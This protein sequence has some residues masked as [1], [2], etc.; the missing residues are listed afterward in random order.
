MKWMKS[1]ETNNLLVGALILTGII[2]FP[3][4]IIDNSLCVF[5]LLFMRTPCRTP[6]EDWLQ[7]RGSCADDLDI[8]ESGYVD[9]A[10]KH[11]HRFY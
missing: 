3:S 4:N 8:V 1:I 10:W 6:T 9:V 5:L 2:A 7:Y 11:T